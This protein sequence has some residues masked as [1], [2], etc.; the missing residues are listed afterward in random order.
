[1][2][3]KTIDTPLKKNQTEFNNKVQVPEKYT[4]R[5]IEQAVAVL[6]PKQQNTK[7]KKQQPKIEI[8]SSNSSNLSNSSNTNSS[9]L[10]N[11]STSTKLI[12][13]SKSFND[14]KEYQNSNNPKKNNAVSNAVS[15]TVGTAKKYSKEYIEE[16]ENNDDGFKVASKQ[17]KFSIK[18]NKQA[19]SFTYKLVKDRT[20]KSIQKREYKKLQKNLGIDPTKKEIKNH[21][22]ETFKKP[23][24]K[25]LK[26]AS[27][28]VLKTGTLKAGQTAESS[29]NR[30]DDGIKVALKESKA[31]AKYSSKMIKGS[32]KLASNKIKP[33]KSN[34]KLSKSTIQKMDK[35]KIE[36]LK[37]K[38]I[39]K[40]RIYAP[41]YKKKF[42][43]KS[44]VNRVTN[45]FKNFT[46]LSFKN[47]I[48][49]IMA[50]KIMAALFGS[51]G[52][53]AI[54]VLIVAALMLVIVGV[55]G[56]ISNEQ[57]EEVEVGASKNL[58]P[59]VERWRSLVEK[60]ANRQGMGS[61]V[62]LILA[63]IQ[64]ETGGKGSRDIMQ[65][66][67]SAGLPMNTFQTEEESVKQ[68]VKHLKNIVNTLKGY[69]K[70]YESNT[71]LLAQ[72][73]NFGVAFASFVGN[74]GGE[75]TLQMAEDYSKTV[76]APSLGNTNGATVPYV[77]PTSIRLG[78]TYRYVNGG[79]F[80]YGEMVGEYLGAAGGN[81]NYILPV[82]NPNIT[83]PY[84]SRTDPITGA[85]GAFHRGL[86]FG[87]PMGTPIKA[88]ADGK[89]ITA[90]MHY[91]WGNHVV[92]LHSDG[93]LSLYAHQ[94]QMLVKAGDEVKQGQVIGKIGSTGDSTGPHLH[95]EIAKSNS[96]AESNL[97][98]PA[99]VLGIK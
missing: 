87:N 92:I 96:L 49:K 67:E 13:D 85:T 76:V 90:N 3:K 91:S 45:F 17:A 10:S 22:K 41:Q 73:Y 31:I 42:L 71:K 80:L 59:E 50:T 35:E 81:G 83:S 93:K 53:I 20:K 78:K 23:K 60:E 62:N 51:A 40:K 32:T 98:D 29:L 72:S 37:K 65:S 75:Y 21:L 94:S 34:S 28:N 19:A 64:V 47:A 82:D 99:I 88:I 8:N 70:G 61:Y 15:K 58:S 68:G 14:T 43:E 2:R 54:I 26:T 57:T 97:L 69:K 18:K 79:N 77:N 12:S 84:G 33:K 30:D 6:E 16:L 46:K 7:L 89:V 27:T 55:A 48:Q 56:G 1:M 95:L 4:D 66:S 63:I 86:D 52:G 36:K 38:K 25:R 44:V 11:S 74:R 24:V 5:K 39:N 9:N